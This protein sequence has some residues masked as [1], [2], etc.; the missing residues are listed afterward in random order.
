MM[1]LTDSMK[2][3]ITE[4]WRALFQQFAVYRP[5]M[6]ARRV[7]PFVNG[8]CL[9]R[10]SGNA[11]YLPTI[12]AHCLCRPFPTISLSMG[13]S[14]RSAKTNTAERITAQFHQ[15]K[16]REAASRLAASSLLPLSGDW[17]MLNFL[18]AINSYRLLG[19]ADSRYPIL[20]FEDAVSCF[21]W[22]RMPDAANMQLA[23]YASEITEWPSA[24]TTRIGGVEGW[25]KKMVEKIGEGEKLR[26]TVEDQVKQHG[27]GSLPVSSLLAS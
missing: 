9:E 5:M 24:V 13:Q 16:H 18:Q 15:E 19:A 23:S 26:T 27:L 21:V 10:D 2:A 6:L 12:F 25:R 17:C 1:K 7:G 4:D 22:L 8:I 20:L 14:L 3:A 11:S